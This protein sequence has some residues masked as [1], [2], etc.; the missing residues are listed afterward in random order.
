MFTQARIKLT[1]WYMLTLMVVSSLFSVVVYN[2]LTFELLRGFRIQE[3]RVVPRPRQATDSS[4]NQEPTN[5]IFLRTAPLFNLRLMLNPQGIRITDTELF[6]EAKQR[7]AMQLLSLNAGILVLSGLF[8]FF[9][10]GKT[11]RPIEESMEEQKRFIADASHE[12]KTP[13][14][15]MR[16]EIEVAL[17]AKSLTQKEAI[18]TLYSNLE[19]VIHM[20]KLS[21]YL[22]SL[23]TYQNNSTHVH[24]QK[25]DIKKTIEDVCKKMQ[26]LASEKQ[27]TLKVSGNTT[28]IYA[29]VVSMHE[30]F[31]IL[32]ENAVKFS[33]NQS[34]V[35]IQ[36]ISN[37]KHITVLI[38]D[39]GIGISQKDIPHIFDRF[40][41]VDPARSNTTHSG[42]GL[43]L[44]IA[45]NI[46][47]NHHGSIEVE[48][49]QK[50]GSTFTVTL[51]THQ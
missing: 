10:A 19:E 48:S 15:A 37:K 26:S 5:A 4:E 29:N 39:H 6:D 40:Y 34:T 25:V 36:V 3:L 30:L 45:K 49:T 47:N 20:Q 42:Y 8:S 33:H 7:I 28:M 11:L 38:K 27:I 9:L 17:R 32:I 12:L 21:E 44:S 41:R 35:D 14:T 24:M 23:H 2:M 18:A 13:I 43:G 51:P 1:L 46:V 16:T 22:L 50:K 31:F